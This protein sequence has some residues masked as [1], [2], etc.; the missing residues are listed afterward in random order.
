MTVVNCLQ[1]NDP[2]IQGY[3]EALVQVFRYV[4]LNLAFPWARFVLPWLSGYNVQKKHNKDM[5][6]MFRG[7]IAEHRVRLDEE[8]PKVCAIKAY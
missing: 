7:I 4:Y 8:A 2:K 6:D 3:I 1:P 5:K